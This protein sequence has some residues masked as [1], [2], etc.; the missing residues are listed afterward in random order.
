MD[1]SAMEICRKNNIEIVVINIDNKNALKDII[2]GKKV[3][4]RV[5]NK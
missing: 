2:N 4:T 1:L 5:Y 3:G